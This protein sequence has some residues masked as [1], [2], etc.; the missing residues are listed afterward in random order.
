MNSAT[1]AR[2]QRLFA[3][4]SAAETASLAGVLAEISR[5]RDRAARLRREIDLSGGNVAQ[6]PSAAELAAASRWSLRLAERVRSEE[7]RAGVLEAEA[8]AI[9]PRLAR[10]IGRESAAATMLEKARIR[11]RRLAERRAE[12]AVV[13]PRRTPDQPDSSDSG[14]AG[15]SVGSPGIA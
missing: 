8:E 3:A 11:E 15:T 2:L 1:L 10:A 12:G 13:A 4:A 14:T 6:G 7:A 5:T 9:R